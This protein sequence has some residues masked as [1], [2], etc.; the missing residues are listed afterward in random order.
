MSSCLWTRR[1]ATR[2]CSRLRTDST[3]VAIRV[4]TCRSGGGFHHCVGTSLARLE[5]RIVFEMLLER[6]SKISLL[7]ERPR[8]REGIVLR[9]LEALT[10]RCVRA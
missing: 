9:G 1:S 5:G 3:S 2:R 6:F 10:V 4:P 8:F 7:D